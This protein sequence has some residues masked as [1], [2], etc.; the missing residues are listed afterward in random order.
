MIELRIWKALLVFVSFLFGCVYFVVRE[1]GTQNTFPKW[2]RDNSGRKVILIGDSV[3]DDFY[4]LPSG[5]HDVA[6]QL[7]QLNHELDVLNYAV[8]EFMIQD[9]REG[10]Y[11]SERYARSRPY[12]YPTEE[13]GKVYPL[14]HASDAD[15]AV[16]SIGG[17]DGRLKI[18]Q[19]DFDVT[20]LQR[21]YCELVKKTVQK[22]RKTILVMVYLPCFAEPPF[23]RLETPVRTMAKNWLKIVQEVASEHN[24]AVIDLSRTFDPSDRTHYGST[25]IEPSVKSGAFIARL[26]DHVISNHNFTESKT[27]WMNP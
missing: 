14:M 1:Y 24:L 4:W 6:E 3:L 27:Y 12:E 23:D 5:S 16:L 11:V 9:V 21:E 20:S 17:N 26:I 13:D 7:S 22:C 25:T 8:D 15:Y 10:G 2:K 18:S 19:G